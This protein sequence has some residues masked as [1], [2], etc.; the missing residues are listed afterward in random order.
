MRLYEF[1]LGAGGFDG[2]DLF[3]YAK[4]WWKGDFDT[5]VMIENL[6]GEHGWEIGRDDGPYENGGVF[7]QMSD[8]LDPDGESYQSWSAE[9]LTQG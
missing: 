6:L 2:D 5:Q 4:K 9:E 1:V 8:E 3:E 7:V